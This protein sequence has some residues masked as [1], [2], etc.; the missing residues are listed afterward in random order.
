MVD[1]RAG[2][3]RSVTLCSKKVQAFNQ[4][5]RVLHEIGQTLIT[6]FKSQFLKHILEYYSRWILTP[7]STCYLTLNITLFQSYFWIAI[8]GWVIRRSLVKCKF[9]CFKP[10]IRIYMQWRAL[11]ILEGNWNTFFRLIFFRLEILCTGVDCSK[12]FWLITK[13]NWLLKWALGFDFVLFSAVVIWV[14]L[15]Y[16]PDWS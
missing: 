12:F 10:L 16:V 11:L 8:A 9:C 14:A 2:Q 3:S 6:N 7:Y 4:Y 1:H 5:S 13:H 15:Y